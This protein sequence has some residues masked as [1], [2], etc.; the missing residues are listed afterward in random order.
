MAMGGVTQKQL[1]DFI[2]KTSARVKELMAKR[3]RSHSENYEL[4]ACRDKLRTA[5]QS[6]KQGVGRG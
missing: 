5:T 3:P 4:T 1:E 6:L 2:A